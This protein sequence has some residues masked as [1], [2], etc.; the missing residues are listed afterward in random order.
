MTSPRR[1][2]GRLI[3]SVALKISFRADKDTAA[4]IKK[5]FPSTKFREGVCE[6]RIGGELPAEV[7]AKA[8]D[9]LET[10]RKMTWTSK[11]FK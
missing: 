5:G 11:G 9:L 8:R 6:V 7:D 2:Q 4:K 1:S 3:E 10:I